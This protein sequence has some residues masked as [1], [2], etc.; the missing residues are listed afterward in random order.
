MDGTRFDTLIKRFG[1]RPL[2]RSTA[3]R[4]LVASVAALAGVTLAAEPGAAKKSGRSV[5]VRTRRRRAARPSRLGKK[6]ARKHLKKHAC[7]YKG[8]C[9]DVSGCCF[10]DTQACT[11]SAQCCSEFC[12]DGTCRPPS[13]R[14]SARAAQASVAAQEPVSTAP[15]GYLAPA[16]GRERPAAQERPSRAAPESATPIGAGHY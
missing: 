3:L 16:S 4:G 8:K 15:A 1:T 10:A 14:A 11:T 5:T 6:A 2:T 9:D 12:G 13:A 7:D